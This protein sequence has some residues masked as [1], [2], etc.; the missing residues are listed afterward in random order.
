ME[1]VKFGEGVSARVWERGS[2]GR[3]L[4]YLHG[5]DRHPGDEAPYLNEWAKSRRVIAPEHPGYGESIGI[6]NVDE[7]IDM[8]LYYRRVIEQLAGGPVDVVGHSLGGMIAAEVAALSPYLVNRL[9]LIA[10]FGL[11]LDEQEIPDLFVMSP[12]ALARNTWA[13]PEGPAAQR[14]MN[15]AANGASGSAAII[16]RA[17]NLATAGRFLWPLPDRGLRKRLAYVK[18]KTLVVTGGSDKLIPPVYGEAFCKLIGNCDSATIANAG[19][20]PMLEQPE[21]FH[22]VVDPF[23]A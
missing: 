17:M 8:S 15:E 3:P 2:G 7:I 22:K 12:N 14:A 21:A 4:L 23:L 16:T 20:Y 19:H 11:W 6:E 5:Y 1:T 9:V 13:D 18:A 10:P